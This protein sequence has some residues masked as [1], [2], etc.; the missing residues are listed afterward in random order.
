MTEYLKT[1]WRMLYFWKMLLAAAVLV[2]AIVILFIE[3]NL[4]VVKFS[5]AIKAPVF[6]LASA[7]TLFIAMVPTNPG[8]RDVYADV[9]IRIVGAVT[10]YL[11]GWHWLLGE[12]G[13]DASEYVPILIGIAG[14]LFILV[15]VIPF[16]LHLTTAFTDVSPFG[17]TSE[18]G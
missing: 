17:E 7:T 16:L 12:T 11:A 6:A 3:P 13:G 8:P 5:P 1:I 2:F 18:D 4:F 9:S 15:V 10:A 14:L